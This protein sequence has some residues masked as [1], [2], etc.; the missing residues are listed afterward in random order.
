MTR[1]FREGISTVVRNFYTYRVSRSN[2]STQISCSSS[3][4]YWKERVERNLLRFV[5]DV[6]RQSRNRFKIPGQLEEALGSNSKLR[7]P[8]ETYLIDGHV[9]RYLD[10]SKTVANDRVVNWTCNVTDEEQEEN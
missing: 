5:G 10:I 7:K 2:R 3:I 1:R 8:S 6:L 9:R 4:R